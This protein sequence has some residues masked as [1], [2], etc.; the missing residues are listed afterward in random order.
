MNPSDRPRIDELFDLALQQPD[1]AARKAFLDQICHGQPEVR[2]R[3]DALLAADAKASR[4]LPETDP[5]EQIPAPSGDDRPAL[6]SDAPV[7]SVPSAVP[8]QQIG[9]YKLLEKIGEGGFGE[10]WMAEQKEP[11]RRRVAL[12]IIK[13]GMDTRQVVARFEAERQ[14]LALMDHPNIAKVFDGGATESGRP[15]FVMELVRGVPITRFCDEAHFTT[16][17]RLELF[18]SVCEALQHA[19]QKG[20]IHRDIKP[21]NVMVTI[22]EDKP[23]VKVIDF[24]IAKAT[25]QDLTDQTAFT[26][27]Q[28]FIGTPAY[29]SPE[30]AGLGG[31]DI[32]TRSD[33]YS[34]GVLLYEL[35][36]GKPPL[37][38]KALTIAGLDE[39]RRCIQEVEAL[40]P[41]TRVS[42]LEPAELATLA[43]KRRVDTQ[44]FQRQIR[45]DL[46]WVVLKALEKD[47][48]RRYES[49]N[50]FAEDLRR[51]LNNEPV[52][53]VAPTAV[54][55][56]TKY[57]RRHRAGLA[58]AAGIAALLV[59][60]AGYSSAQAAKAR[61]AADK[62]S[63]AERLAKVSLGTAEQE[64]NRATQLATRLDGANDQLVR[65]TTRAEF[66]AGHHAL[67]A[68]Q[69]AKGIAR[70]ARALRTDPGHWPAATRLISTLTERGFALDTLPPLTHDQ[71][72]YDQALDRSTGLLVTRGLN[73]DLRVWNTWKAERL[74]DIPAT[75]SRRMPTLSADGKRF[76]YVDTNGLAQVFEPF[77]QP[78]APLATLRAEAP[79]VA[80]IL[81]PAPGPGLKA[82]S[83][84]ADGTVQF[85]NAESGAALSQPL[86]GTSTHGGFLAFTRDGKWLVGSFSDG[87][88]GAWP[89]PPLTGAA[90]TI[91]AAKGSLL[92]L[93]PD[94]RTL[95]ER[96]KDGLSVRFWDLASGEARGDAIR[97]QEPLAR[98]PDELG[99]E[100]HG[101][102]HGH[103]FTFSDDGRQMLAVAH[104]TVLPYGNR[105][106]HPRMEVHLFDLPAGRLVRTIS[107]TNITFHA[108]HLVA[109]LGAMVHNTNRLV[110]RSLSTGTVLAE[111]HWSSDSLQAIEFSPAGDRILVAFTDR[112]LMF[113]DA[114]TGE[115]LTHPGDPAH[116]SNVAG[117]S[118]RTP[119]HT[120]FMRHRER[121]RSLHFSPE[122]EVFLIRDG[123]GAIQ[124][125]D[126]FEGVPLSEPLPGLVGGVEFSRDGRWLVVSRRSSE[127]W[128][129][130]LLDQG[131]V[132]VLGRDLS[133]ARHPHLSYQGAAPV[134]HFSPDGRYGL[135]GSDGLKVFD[136]ST[137]TLIHSI[138][139]A[140]VGNV[141]DIGGTTWLISEAWFSPSGEKIVADCEIGGTRLVKVFETATGRTLHTLPTPRM[142]LPYRVRFAGE[143]R[144]VVGS[145]TYEEGKLPLKVWDLPSDR[146]IAEAKPALGPYLLE[147]SP[148]GRRIASAGKGI[149]L[150]D[151][152]DLKP[153]CPV[154]HHRNSSSGLY[155]LAFSPDSRRLVTGSNDGT[156]QVWKAE[157]GELEAEFDHGET[158][159][160]VGFSPDSQRV[161]AAGSGY[162]DVP[163]L[164]NVWEFANGTTRRVT[165]SLTQ[166]NT[167]VHARF[168]ADSQFLVAGDRGG[169]VQLWSLSTSLPLLDTM[170]VD[171]NGGVSRVGI[172][173][174]MTRVFAATYAGNQLHQRL[175]P[176]RGVTVPD[177][178]PP[179]AEAVAGH[180][181][182]DQ[183]DLEPLGSE[184]LR[185]AQAAVAQ[186]PVP[187]QAGSADFYEQW[188]RWFF[189]DHA[190]RSVAPLASVTVPTEINELL[191]EGSLLSLRRAHRISP[192]D[193]RIFAALA[194]EI[195]SH[196]EFREGAP[197]DPGTMSTAEWYAAQAVERAPESIE[198]HGSR[199]EVLLRLGKPEAALR[200]LEGA[201]RLQADHPNV[202][203]IRSE[204]AWRGGQT[205]EAQTL[206][207]QALTATAPKPISAYL[208][209]ATLAQ[210]PGFFAEAALRNRTERNL[211]GRPV[212]LSARF[213]DLTPWFTGPVA[214][215]HTNAAQPRPPFVAPVL[216][217]GGT[218]FDLRGVI[219]LSTVP[220]HSGRA[221]GILGIPIDQRAARLHFLAGGEAEG[222][223][224]RVHYADRQAR[225]FRVA[226]K[227]NKFG[228]VSWDNPR[229][230][231]PVLS[232]DVIALPLSQPALVAI[233]VQTEPDPVLGTQPHP[234]YPRVT[235]G[236]P[237]E[238][239]VAVTTPGSWSYQWTFNRQ[240]IPGATTPV[241][242]IATARTADMGG[243]QVE[244]QPSAPDPA[245][246][247]VRSR[248]VW[249]V[250]AAD[251]VVRGILKEELFFDV[252]G[253]SVE[254]LLKSRK[255]PGHP[256]AT[257][258]VVALEAPATP[259]ENF[260][261]RLSGWL[262]P[263]ESA[264]YVFYLCSDDCSTLALSTDETAAKLAGIAKLSGAK[265]VR[266]WELLDPESISKPV[267]LEAGKRYFIEVLHKEGGWGSHLS[268]TWRKAGEP[269]P[270][271]GDAPI[272]GEFLQLPAD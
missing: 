72:I 13:L 154:L 220:T 73:Y 158:T 193:A 19:H 75:G 163:S 146:I 76:L 259:H 250:D 219:S 166:P 227:G 223:R 148:D 120:Y 198:A 50:A 144:V 108:E 28:Q 263:K 226:A 194:R 184:R 179:L 70:L 71:P 44:R 172:N 115:S 241:L 232:I 81:S 208:R 40:R 195:A 268:V 168:S 170:F 140:D 27:F 14:A 118:G 185:E 203:A 251:P 200:A 150:L 3:L 270:K 32:D 60:S 128:G 7:C 66:S 103:E 256:D 77:T 221:K 125:W 96:A 57:A 258:A 202:L 49:A 186:L 2:A 17:Q 269:G 181:V 204:L 78:A 167:I 63:E 261:R 180:W 101:T 209:V 93:A 138:S 153:V 266:K 242:R 53:A 119:G 39:V 87:K 41:S 52:S 161:V 38:V 197:T 116:I 12:K 127:G 171:G 240:P 122:G 126:A 9:R 80:A 187:A 88:V 212:N 85:W 257:N 228:A 213:V 107:E 196:E 231:I 164:A 182:N 225:E 23:V 217:V 260:G 188:A 105:I 62:A 222:F 152:A 15:F 97:F 98:V 114:R 173:P 134:L 123:S 218:P 136:P 5:S 249:A 99:V 117:G 253:E 43:R 230:G 255:Y 56:F 109:G 229:L 135:V 82:A 156:V 149:A 48:T 142:T 16:T 37:D 175:L 83:R 137:G 58:L 59:V 4:F 79:I 159:R 244:I 252:R 110:L 174:Q 239:N 211:A 206:L 131:S 191:A 165:R 210:R 132:H 178:L 42:K 121:I 155:S 233:T 245:N 68:G 112:R 26:R 254:N 265:G 139:P 130:T 264:H 25:H 141:V 8:S 267:R 30:Q 216:A 262:V 47:R 151:A 69:P 18:F 67:E 45:G 54:Y 236:Q 22:H 100:V 192:G 20:V 55:L 247:G 35:L 199:A 92:T 176:P 34:L 169:T 84:L 106:L 6:G 133:G 215:A 235:L 162:Y 124:L 86:T 271:N 143:N 91:P 10:V 248:T 145:F 89:T 207:G 147:V 190:S 160:W 237:L 246:R 177:W 224:L 201:V 113:L 31:L 234:A 21:S 61:E 36:T 95:V 11:V 102:S 189:A 64:R 94:S 74:M 33:I 90:R 65:S 24:G 243:Y 1:M 214:E 205:N 129:S 104:D 46:D 157:T 51:Y 272:G 29:M 238:L 183:G 111:R